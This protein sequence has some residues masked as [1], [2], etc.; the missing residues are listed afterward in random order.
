MVAVPAGVDPVQW[1]QLVNKW[2]QPQDKERAAKNAEN[3][4]KQ[5]C[6]H[7]MGRVSSIRR[8]EEMSIRDRLLLW[9]INRMR[10]DGSWSSEEA[11]QKWVTSVDARR[12]KF[13]GH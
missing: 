1:C 4:K 13:R 6:P 5:K 11:R 10:K 7:T 8:Q 12:W 3:A 9:K 2:S